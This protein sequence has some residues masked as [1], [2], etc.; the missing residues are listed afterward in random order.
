MTLRASVP[1]DIPIPTAPFPWLFGPDGSARARRLLLLVLFPALVLLGTLRFDFVFD[2][3]IVVLRDS[4]LRGHL[5]LREIFGNEVRVA[6]V[7]MGYYRP[8][9]SLSYWADR[10]LWGLNPAGF[11]LTNLCWHLLATLLVYAVALRTTRQVPGAWAA[12]MAFGVLPA[13]TEAIGWIQGRTDLISTTLV[14]LALLA[15]L[16]SRDSTGGAVWSWGALG[17]LGFLLALLAKE[18]V[19]PLPLA[20]I[21]WEVSTPDAGP[22]RKRL[23]G[24]SSRIVPLLVAGLA[25]WALRRW[26][27]GELVGFPMS[28][29][30]LGLRILALLSVLAEYGR[31][32]LFPDLRL[33]LHRILRVAPAPA[34]FAAALGVL[35][36]LGGGLWA[37]WRWARR[38]FPWV[39]WLPVMLLPPLCF[40]LYA[41]APETGFFTAE[42]F[43]Y[44]SSVGW[45]V[46]LGS[47]IS[48]VLDSPRGSAWGAIIFGAMLAGYA[49]LTLIRLQPW[50][51][52]ADLYTAMQAQPDQPVAVR[53]Y[54]HNN[55]GTVY[56]DR[57]EFPAARAEFQAA[58]RLKPDYA[59]SLNNMG[60]LLIREG[61]PQEA[62]T[63]LETAIHLDP[64]YIE[65]YG[66]LGAASEAAGDLAAARQAYLAGLR[67][68]PGSPWLAKGLTRVNA[69][70]ASPSPPHARPSP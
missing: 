4:L 42:R 12:A 62:R 9:I 44:L 10:V 68:A 16:C 53:I 38:F 56:L 67:V 26:A 20:W 28:L 18:S 30:P 29:T 41:P 1:A 19:A 6:D 27:V 23:A 2:D 31:V 8:V 14:L 35:L 61:R 34:T 63:W 11:H 37:A 3:N 5:G 40:I 66:N 21:V 65:A 55:L 58:L 33:N 22:W 45:C 48:R 43:L 59:F 15:L 49:G 24:L 52:A 7:V 54:L 47:L 64:A 51:D 60:V 46:L 17:G 39:A 32:L 57:G 69:E 25:Y 50:A 13:H 36:V 70:G